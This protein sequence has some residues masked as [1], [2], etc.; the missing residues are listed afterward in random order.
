MSLQ[1]C[2]WTFGCSLPGCENQCLA[3]VF[4]RIEDDFQPASTYHL[5]TLPDGPALPLSEAP[6]RFPISRSA[7]A[8]DAYRCPLLAATILNLAAANN[9][10]LTSSY[11]LTAPG[12]VRFL[13][14]STTDSSFHEV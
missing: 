9:V 3:N 1:A 4:Q 7:F 5:T 13:Q 8:V 14:A 12:V 6:P 2:T 10:T 11:G